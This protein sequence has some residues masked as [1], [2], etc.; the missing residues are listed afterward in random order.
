MVR[1]PGA[2][3]FFAVLTAACGGSS[4]IERSSPDDWEVVSEGVADGAAPDLGVSQTRV[5]QLQPVT[6]STSMDQTAAFDI[7]GDPSV[8]T[9]IDTDPLRSGQSSVTRGYPPPAAPSRSV[10]SSSVDRSR[11]PAVSAPPRQVAPVR[12]PTST[13]VTPRP[14]EEEP[15]RDPE[16]EP[17]RRPA[18]TE[19]A[20]PSTRTAPEPPPERP[21][22]EPPA[23]QPRRS[24]EPAEEPQ[25]PPP[26]A[27]AEPNGGEEPRGAGS[28][29][30][31]RDE[32]RSDR[33]SDARAR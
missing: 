27:T 17:E 33:R 10:P 12:P 4:D 24:D 20:P 25:A 19:T 30:D 5:E 26:T 29:D 9:A 15:R 7:V 32:Q 11:Q 23:E 1:Y 18:P 14:V 21:A 2:V 22:D 31:D 3:I 16:P 6:T 8:S 28:G 13:R